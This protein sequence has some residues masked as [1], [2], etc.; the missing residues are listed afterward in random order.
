MIFSLGSLSYPL[1]P[2]QHFLYFVV[3]SGAKEPRQRCKRNLTC[4]VLTNLALSP[5]T[6]V[7][8]TNVTMSMRLLESLLLRAV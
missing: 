5:E 4:Q 1:M 7:A 6:L 8:L 3:F 2:W